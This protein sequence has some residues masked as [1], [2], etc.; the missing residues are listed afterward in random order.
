MLPK[1]V[2]KLVAHHEV[3][4][5]FLLVWMWLPVIFTL[6]GFYLGTWVTSSHTIDIQGPDIDRGGIGALIGL[7]I[8]IVNA[9][10]VS[11]IYPKKIAAEYEVREAAMRG[12]HVHH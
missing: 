3:L 11:S 12:E 4:M 10:V 1:S 2:R 7:A 9:L 5:C 8:A 6:A